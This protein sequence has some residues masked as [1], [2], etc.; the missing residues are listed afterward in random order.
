[1]KEF[2]VDTVD[3][4]KR[5]RAA[6]IDKLT[7][8][9]LRFTHGPVDRNHAKRSKTHPL[10]ERTQ[11]AYREWK[12][13]SVG[14]D[15]TPLP[16]GHADTRKLVA[17]MVGLGLGILVCSNKD[18]YNN[19]KFFRELLALLQDGVGKRDMAAEFNRKLLE[20]GRRI[21]AEDDF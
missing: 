14:A 4:W 18:I 15:L 1:L 13:L 19:D 12:G 10:W 5:K 6:I 2:G 20:L 21:P 11:E 3:D 7:T 8:D 17:Q 9:R 16:I